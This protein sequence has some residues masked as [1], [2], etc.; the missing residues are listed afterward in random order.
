[1]QNKKTKIAYFLSLAFLLVLLVFMLVAGFFL[2]HDPYATNLS[3]AFI[4]AGEEG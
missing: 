2:K 1:M 3:D 4:P